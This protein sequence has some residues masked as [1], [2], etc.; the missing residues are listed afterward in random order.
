MKDIN[1]GI[2]WD[3][4][5]FLREVPSPVALDYPNRNLTRIIGA[6]PSSVDTGELKDRINNYFRGIQEQSNRPYSLERKK[7]QSI[8]DFRKL[9]DEIAQAY[10][11]DVAPKANTP[12]EVLD[13]VLEDYKVSKNLKDKISLRPYEYDLGA[14]G[15]TRYDPSSGDISISLS[16]NLD[17]S[18]GTLYHEI[19]H[20]FNNIK[21]GGMENSKEHLHPD[22]VPLGN[23][24]AFELADSFGS[25]RHHV[26]YQDDSD[27]TFFKKTE[28]V[29]PATLVEPFVKAGIKPVPTMWDK[30]KKLLNKD[31]S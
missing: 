11:E 12:Y 25:T 20:A 13:K 9:Q 8:H 31:E 29:I 19:L 5:K 3:E 2:W 23:P 6:I 1:K 18:R 14:S 28:P 7:E 27:T 15:V 10:I 22:Y 30:V 26:P 21:Y 24:N 4:H 16:P 17:D